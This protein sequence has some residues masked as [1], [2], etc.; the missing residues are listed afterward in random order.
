MSRYIPVAA[1][2][3]VLEQYRWFRRSR[4]PF[5]AMDLVMNQYAC[6]Y[7]DRAGNGDK[8][9]KAQHYLDRYR[10]AHWYL[11]H[12]FELDHRVEVRARRQRELRAIEEARTVLASREAHARA[13]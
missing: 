9:G 6:G 10:A 5:D 11:S 1:K 12:I 2:R 4:R 8:R 3:D 7:A 13:S